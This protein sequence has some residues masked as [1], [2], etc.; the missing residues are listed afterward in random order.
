M[1]I[2]LFVVVALTLPDMPFL[3]SSFF[4]SVHFLLSSISNG[5]RISFFFFIS[6]ITLRADEDDRFRFFPCL[7]YFFYY[8]FSLRTSHLAPISIRDWC[9]HVLWYLDMKC[10]LAAS[11]LENQGIWRTDCKLV[12]DVYEQIKKMVQ[13][14]KDC[15]I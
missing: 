12:I 14:E 9:L 3:L 15:V 7:Q 1:M 5:I 6:N 8:F 2:V 4:K 11:T 10:L 13:W